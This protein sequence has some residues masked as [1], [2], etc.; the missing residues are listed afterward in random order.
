[1]GDSAHTIDVLEAPQSSRSLY[2]ASRE[3]GSII[4]ERRATGVELKSENVLRTLAALSGVG[5]KA[6]T[7]VVD[8]DT[9]CWLQ[10]SALG[11]F[12]AA[13]LGTRGIQPFTKASDGDPRVGG[14]RFERALSRLLAKAALHSGQQL[15]HLG[16]IWF[17]GTVDVDGEPTQFCFPA[18]SM[19]MARPTVSS[20]AEE[21]LESL[22][23]QQPKIVG[24]LKSQTVMS[25]FDSLVPS[26][27]AEVTPLVKD[28]AL[29]SRLLE[30]AAFGDSLLAAG[31]DSVALE[32]VPDLMS[33][34]H[35]VAQAVGLTVSRTFPLESSV[36]TAQ[37]KNDG[38]SM[39][40]GCALYLA[41]PASEGS[42]Q[43]SLI[44]LA[45][46][47]GLDQTAFG[48]IYGGGEI[49]PAVEREVLR[50]RPLSLR[51]ARVAGR[52]GGSDVAVLSGAPGTGKSHVL[53]VIARDAVARGESVLVAAGSPHAV[54]VLVEHFAATPGPTPVTFG[55]SRHGHRLAGE[56]SELISRNEVGGE[57][58]SQADDQFRSIESTRRSLRLEMEAMRID[59]DPAHRI[60]VVAEVDRAGDLDDLRV[61]VELNA[62][63]G[64][65]RF[66]H[67]KRV[68][69]AEARLGPGD[70]EERLADLTRKRDALRLL[71]ADGMS[72]T[73]RLDDIAAKEDIAARMRGRQ[74]TDEWISS[75]GRDE[76]RTLAQVSS[77]VTSN[78]SARRRALAALD[79]KSLTR[80]APLWIGSVRDVDEV[81]PEVAGLFDLVILDEAAQIDQMNAANALVRAKRAVVCGDPN[82]LG[83]TS[84][85]SGEAVAKATRQ[86]GTNAE[87]LNPRSV[88]TYDVVAAQVPV[89]VLDEHFRSVPHLIEFSSR[90]FY[91]GDL[92]VATRHPRSDAADHIHVSV[93]QGTRNTSKVNEAEVEEC[94]RL[95]EQYAR[96]GATSI[97]LIS[98]FRAQADALEEAILEKYRLE[99]IDAYGL[100]V[101]TVHSYQGD[102]RDVLIISLAVGSDEADS[103]WRFV[104]QAN[105]F[106]V[107]VTR[108][109]EEVVVVTSNPEPPGLA[110][111]YIE[112]SEPLSD[113][114]ADA[115][116]RDP[117]IDRIAAALREQGIPVRCGYRVGRH[118]IDIVAGTGEHAVAVE[119]RPHPDGEAVHLDRALMLRRSGWKTADAYRT[120]WK[121]NPSQFAIEL[122][123]RHPQLRSG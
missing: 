106:N 29:R 25:G 97:G 99:E 21:T 14:A 19:P 22:G 32:K 66:G 117:W 72:L 58:T 89:E 92:H 13:S 7:D 36:P 45:N 118:H 34:S 60:D 51:Q 3:D 48:K 123:S 81:L 87:L 77:A 47:P 69:A 83:H 107:M 50:L 41:D 39:H 55:G 110:G 84:F 27:D 116:L 26:G 8:P 95:V 2:F 105:L 93:V 16:W 20:K 103:A 114:V 15:I 121:D 82:Q 90:R 67:K 1:M 42:R 52:A 61:M 68:E 9:F 111:E 59:S 112:W 11:Y 102:E 122:C 101:G 80:A 65:F 119:C 38:I 79:P 91:G 85:V 104:N 75:L 30:Q 120:R 94:L 56:L 71:A 49:R 86:F 33:W 109:R 6:E 35:E 53:S 31:A 17:A 46:L 62:N 5:K 78:R 28:A 76:K 4:G 54:D 70:A 18:L 40:L 24:M 100:R 108:A 115:K 63:P 98:P 44:G 88:S 96:G 73:P 64:F 57:T 74:L 37:R 23:P 12:Y 113:L 10:H 43:S